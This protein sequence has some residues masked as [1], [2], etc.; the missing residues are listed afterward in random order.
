MFSI[1]N[2]LQETG[3]AQRILTVPH[4]PAHKEDAV[5]KWIKNLV[6]GFFILCTQTC[7]KGKDTPWDFPSESSLYY[8]FKSHCPSKNLDF[9]RIISLPGHPK[10]MNRIVFH[11]PRKLWL[12]RE[13]AREI[14]LPILSSSFLKRQKNPVKL[15]GLS[16]LE[17]LYHSNFSSNYNAN[18]ILRKGDPWPLWIQWMRS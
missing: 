9:S 7:H 11:Q 18:S 4:N 3:A 2:A 14:H 1:N 10:L 16:T 17:F 12:A 5:S 15:W 8:Y 13:L 6:S